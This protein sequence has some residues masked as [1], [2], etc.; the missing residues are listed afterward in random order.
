VI[1]RNEKRTTEGAWGGKPLGNN[2]EKIK[3]YNSGEE[4]KMLAI[5]SHRG[6]AIALHRKMKRI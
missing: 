4:V 1:K 5:A 2:S 3:E 6:K